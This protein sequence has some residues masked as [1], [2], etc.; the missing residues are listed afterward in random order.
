MFCLGDECDP[1]ADGD[2]ILNKAD[3]CPLVPNSDQRDADKDALGDACDNCPGVKNPDQKDKDKDFVGDVCDT[4]DDRGNRPNFGSWV[5][6]GLQCFSLSVGC[7]HRSRWNTRY[8]RQLSEFP[9]QRPVRYR[10]GC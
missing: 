1:D 2:G 10:R 9:Q 3:N 8:H 6:S 7:Q 4:N 5:E